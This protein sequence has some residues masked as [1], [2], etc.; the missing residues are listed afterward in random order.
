VGG[1]K[2][3]VQISG[4]NERRPTAKCERFRRQNVVELS[5]SFLRILQSIGIR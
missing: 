2:P 3:P 1:S 4:E 5:S